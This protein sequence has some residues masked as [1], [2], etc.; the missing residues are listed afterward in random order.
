MGVYKGWSLTKEI[1]MSDYLNATEEVQDWSTALR[2]VDKAVRSEAE[3]L[4]DCAGLQN[5]ESFLKA[6]ALRAAWKRIQRG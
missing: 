3:R 1:D 5:P 6:E 2:W 4:Q